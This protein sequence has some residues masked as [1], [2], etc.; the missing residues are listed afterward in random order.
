MEIKTDVLP[1]A[2]QQLD[3]SELV[4]SYIPKTSQVAQ[5]SLKH[6]EYR[7]DYLITFT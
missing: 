7:N 6:G 5:Q 4:T 3:V 1:R 2:I